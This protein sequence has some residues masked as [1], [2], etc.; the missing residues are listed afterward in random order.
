[1]KRILFYIIAL[2]YLLS[3]PLV[4]SNVKDSIV[5]S[6]FLNETK[7]GDSIITTIEITAKGDTLYHYKLAPYGKYADVNDLERLNKKNEDKNTKDLYADNS[8][9]SKAI[10]L[11]TVDQGKSVGEIPF[12]EGM[13][14]SGGKT[15]SIPVI[16]APVPSGVPQVAITYNS[17]A[18]NGVAGFG[19]NVAGMSVITVS[20]KTNYYDGVAEPVNL[21]NPDSCVF[22]LDGTRLV[23][24]SGSVAE[25]QY[26][27]AQGFVLV[28]KN[29]ASSGAV[30]FFDVM[31]PNGSKAVFGFTNNT[32][33]KHIYP[34]TSLVD[35]KGY[36]I[37]F[38][39]METGNNY[40]ISKIRYGGKTTTSHVAEIV[41]QYISRTDYTSVYL[42]DVEINANQL[43]KKIISYNNG[44]ELRTYTLTHTFTDNVN[45][46]TQLDC[47]TGSLS[48][49]PLSF[50]YDMY[51]PGQN[52]SLAVDPYG[53]ILMQYFPDNALY[54]RGKLLKNEFNDGLVTYP[55]FSTY[56]LTGTLKKWVPFHYNYYYQFGSLY[57]PD[58]NFLIAPRLDYVTNMITIKAEDGFQAI[59]CVDVNGDGTDEIVKINF[60]GY[61]GSKTILKITVYSITNGS[62]LN[63]RSFNVNVE[64]VVLDGDLV[65]PISRSYYFGDF[66]GDG[67]LQLLTVSHNKNFKNESV[68]SYFD[69]INLETGSLTNIYPPFS[70]TIDEAVNVADVNGDGKS[71][72]CRNTTYVLETYTLTTSNTFVSLFNSNKSKN[73]KTLYADL[74]GDGMMDMLTPPTESYE[75]SAYYEVPIWAPATCPSCGGAYPVRNLGDYYCR[76]CGFDFQNYYSFMGSNPI[77]FQ[78][79][80]SLNKCN[81]GSPNPGDLELLCCTEHG[82]STLMK[83]SDGYVDN[84]NQW[85]AYIATGKGYVT[86]YFNIINTLYG[87]KYYLMDI[88]RDGLADL[89]Q[90]R[91]N[92]IIPYLSMN[93]VIQNVSDVSPINIQST[94][95]IV[96]A[97]L[98]S[99]NLM[100]HF[101]KVDGAVVS[102]YSFTKDESKNHLLTSMT[103]SYGLTRTNT[104]DNMVERNNYI[105]TATSRN[106]PYNS[107]IAPL[108]L[109]SSTYTYKDNTLIS[110]N[111]FTYYGAVL[112]RTGLGFCGFEKIRTIDY[113]NNITT[114]EEKNPELFGVTIRVTSPVIATS[115]YYQ[116]NLNSVTKT[117][118]P[119]VFHTDEL[120]KLTNISKSNHF[121]S[122]EYN[123]ITTAWV[124]LS[125]NS[126]STVT[127]QTYCSTVT[128]GLYLIGQPMVKTE[129]ITRSGQSWKEKEDFIYNA[130]H[131]PQTRVTYT[132]VNGD[133]KTGETQWTY[134][135][136]GNVTSEKSAPYSNTL[137]L[138]K[139]YTYDAS[140][141]YPASETNAM[142]QTTT[143]SNYDKYGNA[144]TI[145]NYKGKVTT[146]VFDDWGQLASTLYPD[147]VTENVTAAWGGQ[148][149]Y[150]VTSA[151][152]GKPATITHYDALGREVR[153]GN[154]RFDGQWQYTDKVYDNRGRLEKT[155]MPFRASPSLWNTYMYDTYNRPLTLTEASGKM[156][157][158]SYSGNSVT[159]TK[160]GIAS[161]KIQDGSG[162]LISV[163]DPGGTI[164][165]TLRPD[166]QPVSITSP[167][168]V[169]TSFTY[170]DYGRKTSINDPSA[171]T[172]MFTENYSGN[173]KTATVI[174]AN[175][176]TVSTIYDQYGRVTNVNR[177]EFNTTYT[178]NSDGQLASET[179]TNGTSKTYSYDSFGRVTNDVENC[180]VNLQHAYSY[181]DGNLSS[182]TTTIYSGNNATENY[183]Y[184]NGYLTE[185]KLNGQISIWKLTEENDLGQPTKSQTGQLVRTYEYTQ[186]GMPTRR[187]AGAIQDFSYNFE[188]QTG[189]LLSRTDNKRTLTEYFQYDNLNRLSVVAG[190]NIV[191]EANGNIT[192]LPGTGMLTYNNNANPYQ[193]TMLTPTGIAVPIRNQNITYTSF[194]RPAQ[195]TEGTRVAEFKYNANGDRVCTHFSDA[196]N[197]Y[198]SEHYLV[199]NEYEMWD[200]NDAWAKEILY[201]GGDAYSAPAVLVIPELDNPWEIYYICRDYLGSITHITN[202]DGS[203]KQE[204]SYD[205]WG[206]LRNPATQVAFAPDTEP[207]LF[208]GRGYTGHEHLTWFGL[209]NMNARLYDPALGRFLS[210]D[211][212]VQAPDFTQN[213]NRYSYCLNNPL[214]YVDQDGEFIFTLICF[215]VPGL[216]GLIP[217]AIAA[218]LSWMSEYGAQVINNINVSNQFKQMGFDGLTTGQILFGNIDWFDVGVA[219]I[220]GGLSAYFPA[221]A[222]YLKY[223]TP[224]LTNSLDIYGDGNV[225]VVGDKVKPWNMYFADTG[226]EIG[227]IALTDVA[228]AALKNDG[229]INKRGNYEFKDNLIK[230][231]T[232]YTPK[233]FGYDFMKQF[234]ENNMSYGLKTN[235]KFDLPY[236][237][238]PYLTPF[239]QDHQLP[240][241]PFDPYKE[242]NYQRKKNVQNSLYDKGSIG[243]IIESLILN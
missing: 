225:D 125:D 204:L 179:S 159:E 1:M 152:T 52:G 187:T 203:L 160:N 8:I 57:S 64:G 18:G 165:Y 126:L 67:K 162:Q 170:D 104:F 21:S 82:M 228:N 236:Y 231:V 108:N 94:T 134:D 243:L 103:D 184:T 36:R 110:N 40:Y 45:R 229:F 183:S 75:N 135:S 106:Y 34:L 142:N 140:G 109:L 232:D 25:Y 111:Y 239:L 26:E 31:Y 221:A 90:I 86:K 185:I 197:N 153:T 27:T 124:S 122:D 46:L 41:F 219:G 115:Y 98:N 132:G 163:T 200:G 141:R 85:I 172:Q 136:N 11:R 207:A 234:I 32:Q 133:K 144:Q 131:L 9:N 89:I 227:S 164:T 121:S 210:P 59:N 101:I 222:P 102:C 6:I 224:F 223:S 192:Q 114:E 10:V 119:F 51:Y 107:F 129:T 97:N 178:Y 7:K 238:N 69:L 189:N 143:Y 42:S 28:K 216:Q 78:C 70:H 61:T 156:T 147:G 171:G 3:S 105:P 30:M 66:N 230:S 88:N 49:N 198:Y 55:G 212:Y 161:T 137:F 148:G 39:Y 237:E 14:P 63:T 206:R 113:V 180:G 201:L 193:V 168:S 91:N 190:N 58:Q 71:E 211:P 84:G 120:N 50:N 81:G 43:L 92:Q 123:N 13:T 173:Q 139:T 33:M 150:T 72:L 35:I 38:E 169:V 149:L 95:G 62:T 138:G 155:S 157:S 73:S 186:Y 146:R 176:K 24:N 4:W 17:Q 181:S 241:P 240:I 233:D 15:Y 87:D 130:N 235:Y 23:A 213:F 145:T 218:D 47:S 65:S 205:A 194:Q 29:V 74:N 99:Y 202:A 79:S 44:Q 12:T 154:Q 128:S 215:F 195:I 96:Q 217:Y 177:T 167:G 117:A 112:H 196:S 209:I 100:S 226:L 22:T 220:S 2:F 77:C 93:G 151:T 127:T 191:Y 37:D 48:L 16:T 214:M 68:T 242:L 76:H 188:T 56:G 118:N 174:D 53:A 175:G 19:W 208:L 83:I 60:N 158:W 54:Q 166:G 5:S 20:P 182:K 80:A 116:P 199:N